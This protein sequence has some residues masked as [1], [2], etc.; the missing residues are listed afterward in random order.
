MKLK[1]LGS[2]GGGGIP[3]LF[4]SCSV[5]MNA[6]N[7]QGK[8]LRRRSLALINDELVIDLPC[9]ARD[10][11][12]SH[13]VDPAN[14]AYILITHSHYDHF[15]ADNLLTRPHGAKQANLYISHESGKEFA[16][17]CEALGKLSVY[18]S[19]ALVICTTKI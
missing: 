16:Q 1:Y 9:D 14:I 17:R 19:S 13:D 6:R 10:G 12:I 3:E 18:M 5:C 7:K 11:F 4:C 8:E 15:L 2:G